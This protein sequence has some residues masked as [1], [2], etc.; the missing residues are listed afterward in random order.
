MTETHDRRELVRFGVVWLASLA[1]GIGSSLTWFVLGVWVF[2]QTGSASQY[3]FV[4][5][6]GMLPSVL[7]GPFAGVVIDRF[8]R[9]TVM[10]ITDTVVALSTA[11]IALLLATGGLQV[12]HIYVAAAIGSTSGV[13]HTTAY[14]AIIPL[15]TPKRHLGRV[16]GL[17]QTAG[18]L[19]I[20]APLAAGALIGAVGMAGVLVIDLTTF[21][22]AVGT[23]LLMRLP[24]TVLIPQERAE[25][26]SFR[27]DLAYGWR[28]LRA[29][30]GLFNL[31]LVLTAYNFAFGVAGVLV[32]PLILSFASA[33]TL[34]VLMFAGGS[35]LFVGG[36]VMTAWGGPKRRVPGV[37]LFA[38]LGGVALILHTLRPSA[39][40]VGAAAAAFL[41]TLPVVQGSVATVFQTKIEPT[42]LGRVMGTTH[43]LAQLAMPISY[44]VAG[45]LAESV[46]GPALRPG[47]PL[48]GSLGALVGVGEERGIAAMLLAA[49]LLLLALAAVMLLLPSL[50]RVEHDLPDAGDQD[51]GGETGEGAEREAA[52]NG[53]PGNGEDAGAP[54]GDTDRETAGNTDTDGD[55]PAPGQVTVPA[56]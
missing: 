4:M 37:A 53:G 12:W 36:L 46:L 2:Q 56:P 3:A 16:N 18:A 39:L 49:G 30:R 43:T 1:S 40:L 11:G 33:A 21:F 8:N 47:G 48:A 51:A 35:G 13:F 20:A 19:H 14:S 50:R 29:R 25:P 52:R 55:A 10:V 38:A 54:G 42:A 5:L 28:Y 9:R 27:S 7:V 17:M 24:A 45:P 22:V 6:S 31:A 23:L 41:F 34:G 44:L 32:Q 26:P 15:L